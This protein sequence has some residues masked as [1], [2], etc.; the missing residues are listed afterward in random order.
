MAMT[1]T[2]P[3]DP[4]ARRAAELFTGLG[5]LVWTVD[6]SPERVARWAWR[7]PRLDGDDREL[8]PV[9]WPDLGDWC[10][11]VAEHLAALADTN[12]ADEGTR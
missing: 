9:L 12:I 8:L 1:G 5:T 11:D 6:L 2:G 10:R 3:D 4:L 7:Q